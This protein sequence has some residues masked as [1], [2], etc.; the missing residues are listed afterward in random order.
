MCLPYS[1]SEAYT[2]GALRI[3]STLHEE[4]QAISNPDVLEG[5]L[6]YMSPEQTGR[7][8]RKLDYRTDD[9]YMPDPSVHYLNCEK[10]EKL[11]FEVENGWG[12]KRQ[13]VEVT[14]K[15]YCAFDAAK[16]SIRIIEKDGCKIGTIH[17]WYIHIRGVNQLLK[18]TLETRFKDCDAL[19]VD[20]R[21]RGGSA[22]A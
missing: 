3:S 5:T 21:G 7:M 14:A 15:D 10:G 18:E 19:I 8:N 6:Y 4:N 11:K 9:A 13:I 2:V 20:L 17:F 16:A 22:G 12:K 1:N